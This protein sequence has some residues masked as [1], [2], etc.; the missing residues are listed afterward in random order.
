MWLFW[1]APSHQPVIGPEDW[2]S[3]P[4]AVWTFLL[5]FHLQP[6]FG[7]ER[8]NLDVWTLACWER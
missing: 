6:A 3:F 8:L 1:L 7:L 5:T 4:L 2:I